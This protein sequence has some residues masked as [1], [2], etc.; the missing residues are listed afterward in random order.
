[1]KKRFAAL[2][3][4][5]SLL[6]LCAAP[7]LADVPLVTD[8]VG[9]L[10]RGELT[11]L[12]ARAQSLREEYGC[13]LAICVVD[14]LNGWDVQ[15]FTEKCYHANYGQGA[16]KS[17]ALLLLS[18]EFRDYDL[19]TYGRCDYIPY[20]RWES[21]VEEV[22][23]YLSEGAYDTAFTYFLQESDALIR[24]NIRIYQSDGSGVFFQ[25]TSGKLLLSLLIG[26]VAALI[27]TLVLRGRMKSAVLQR[28]ADNYAGE[29]ELHHSEDRFLSRDVSRVRRSSES[30]GGSRGGGGGSHHSGKF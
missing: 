27:V 10:T 2:L 8:E 30:S 11:I 1:M 22:L 3:L 5:M 26:A 13:D 17:G 6:F 16:E 4:L 29:L 7:A 20:G 25:F 28:E 19:Y 21:V 18:M 15:Q 24:K 14:S 12:E 23:P 9:L